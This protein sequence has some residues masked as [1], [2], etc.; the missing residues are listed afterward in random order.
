MKKIDNIRV[1]SNSTI[2]ETLTIIRNGAIKIALVMESK[3][4]LGVIT[5]G[6]IRDALLDSLDSSD[7]LEF[8]DT[9]ENIYNRRPIV[10]YENDSK[11]DIMDKALS[12][13]IQ[14]IPI[15]NDCG[16]VIG[17]EEI[18]DLIKPISKSNKVVLMV[19]GLGTRLRPLTENIPKPMLKVGDKPILETI[20]LN[21]K[22]YGFTDIVMCVN[23]KSHVIEEHFGDGSNFGIKIEYIYEKE[24]MGTAGALSLLSSKPTEPFFVMNGD[25]LTKVN[26]E[27]LLNHHV[28]NGSIATMCLRKYEY[29]IPYGVVNLN[30]DK[31]IISIEEKPQYSYFINGGIYLINPEVLNNIPENQFFDMPSLFEVLLKNDKMCGSYI[32]KEYWLDIG[33]LSDYE[34]ANH[35]YGNFFN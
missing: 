32:I 8:S 4:L 13:K 30:S 21:F 9:I 1:K 14:Q 17:I 25:L 22:K 2:K 29:D 26:F 35:E 33:R 11:Q 16:E 5:D 7:S 3:K 6:D 23:Y 15:L 34:K 28:S 20:V 31:N 12:K 19:G 10:C 24:R 27:H 18:D